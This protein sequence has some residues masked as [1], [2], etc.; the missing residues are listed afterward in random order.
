V[1]RWFIAGLVG[2]GDPFAVILLG[3]VMSRRRR[4]A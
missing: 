4:A 3:V 2:C 1:V